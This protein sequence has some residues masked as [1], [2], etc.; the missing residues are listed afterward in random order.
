MAEQPITAIPA[1]SPPHRL[2]TFDIQ[3]SD[4]FEMAMRAMSAGPLSLA[5]QVRQAIAF[6]K[7]AVAER[8]VYVIAGDTPN[9]SKI[10]IANNPA[11][12]LG[13]IQSCH[14][15]ALRIEAL[16][17][18][19]GDERAVERRAL[20]KADRVSGEWVRHSPEEAALLVAEAILETETPAASSDMFL[21]NRLRHKE[22]LALRR[23]EFQDGIPSRGYTRMR[24]G[25][26]LQIKTEVLR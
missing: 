21:R 18:I 2:E 23:H 20:N 7:G 25:G 12:R 3:T 13:E 8:A 11:G 17:W 22:Q 14:W 16:F 15:D 1:E 26:R 4:A 6:E 5:L 9:V 24:L 19:Y 10:G